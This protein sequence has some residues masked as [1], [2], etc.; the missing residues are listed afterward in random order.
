MILLI[1][2]IKLINKAK[3][4]EQTKTDKNKHLNTENSVALPGKIGIGEE[5][6]G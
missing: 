2:K 5:Q 6:N 3:V 1:W 4:K